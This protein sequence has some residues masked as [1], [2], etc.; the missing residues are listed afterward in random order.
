M[1]DS[2]LLIGCTNESINTAIWLASLNKSVQ[3]LAD[4]GSVAHTLASYKFDH[5]MSALWQMYVQTEQITVVKSPNTAVYVWLF[6]DAQGV[7]EYLPSLFDT[8]AQ[9][10]LSGSVAIGDVATLANQFTTDHVC[11]VPF[12]FMKDGTG[13]GSLSSPDLVLIGEK[14]MGCHQSNA[15]LL[16]LLARSEQ[17]FID[18]IH[19]IEFARSSIMAMLATRLSFM[20][21]MA[22]LA[23]AS[24]VDIKKVQSILSKDKRIGKDYLSAGWGFGGQTLPNEVALLDKF[25]QKKQVRSQLLS[26]VVNINEDQKELIF[27]KFWRYFDGFIDHKSVMI[28]GAGYRANTGLTVNSAIHPLLKLLWS[29]HIKTT[30]YAPNA[31]FELTAFYGD[32]PLFDLCDDAYQLAHCDALFILNWSDVI[33]PDVGKLNQFGLPMFDAKNILTNKLVEQY[34]GDYHGIGRSHSKVEV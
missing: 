32:E 30:I 2:I 33:L 3:L 18:D 20:N 12:V 8:T 22:R 25:F 28:W 16:N 13:F 4:E 15:L 10:I 17:W 14:H 34:T 29:Y 11:Y 6:L 5:Q 31:G 24:G 26:T 21:E 27:R 23:D 19:T 7:D 9:V 1:T